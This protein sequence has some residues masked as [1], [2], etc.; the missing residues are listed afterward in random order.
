[1]KVNLPDGWYS[2]SKY[3][4][5][6]YC[7]VIDGEP[8]ISLYN[9]SFDKLPLDIETIFELAQTKFPE[10]VD[11]IKASKVGLGQLGRDS[12]MIYKHS[13]LNRYL[14]FGSIVEEI[15]PSLDDNFWADD[16]QVGE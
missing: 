6:L 11:G 16:F 5:D 12:T 10:G 7:A 4:S 15:S 8:L 13:Y 1:M 14:P 9:I 2:Y 3:G